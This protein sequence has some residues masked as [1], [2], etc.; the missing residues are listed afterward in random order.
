MP[1]QE[2]PNEAPIPLAWDFPHKSMPHGALHQPHYGVVPRLEKF[3]ELRDGG[4]ATAGVAGHSEQQLMLLRSDAVGTCHS[5]AEAKKTA[6]PVPKP[7]E[8]T[9]V[10][11]LHLGFVSAACMASHAMSLYHNVT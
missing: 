9:E 8:V 5:L 6:E 1:C 2:H 4:V 10:A 7:R 11:D 3:G